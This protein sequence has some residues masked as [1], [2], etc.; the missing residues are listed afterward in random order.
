MVYEIHY[1]IY[2]YNRNI[3]L[4]YNKSRKNQKAFKT[5]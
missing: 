3:R 4:H 2:A 5:L 1:T